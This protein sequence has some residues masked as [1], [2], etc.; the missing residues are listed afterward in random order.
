MNV[1]ITPAPLSG[2]IGGSISVVAVRAVG[3]SFLK[4][5]RCEET[6]DFFKQGMGEGSE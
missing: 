2:R 4:P 6:A 3:D 5:I 1:T